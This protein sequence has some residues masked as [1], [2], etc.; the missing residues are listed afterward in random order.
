MP[1]GIPFSLFICA[2]IFFSLYNLITNHM[3]FF[4]ICRVPLLRASHTTTTRYYF[5]ND[6]SRVINVTKNVLNP[7]F[8]N[9]Y[10]TYTFIYLLLK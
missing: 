4:L 1:M 10:T 8:R 5:Y 9:M 6:I 2:L 7:N 3:P